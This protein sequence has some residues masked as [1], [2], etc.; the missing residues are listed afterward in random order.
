MT[1][2][3]PFENSS[4]LLGLR[5]FD[6][7]RILHAARSPGVAP[8]PADTTA[9]KCLEDSVSSALMSPPPAQTPPQLIDLPGATFT[10]GRAD[11]RPD[12]RPPHLVRLAPFR[13]ART[14]VSNAE[15]ARFVADVAAD[16]AP[17][18]CDAGFDASD[19]PVVGVSWFQAAAYCVWLGERAG[20]PLRLPTEAEREF[21]ALGGRAQVDWPWGDADPATCTELDFIAAA[22]GPHAPR[23][24]CANGYGLRCMAD[25]VHEWCLEPYE[26]SYAARAHSSPAVPNADAPLPGPG[27][28]DPDQRRVSRGGSWRHRVKFTRVSARSSL[29]PG[30]RYNDYGFRVYASG[31]GESPRLALARPAIH[32]AP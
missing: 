3:D 28:I 24:A 11:R 21:A 13:A 8:M 6:L 26:R 5:R 20:L 7:P 27:S 4:A 22:A 9:P 32:R 16:A 18:S 15:Y 19:Q 23:P 29:R 25:N 12:E 31:I 2:L 14:P 30:A 17:F 10:M 1:P